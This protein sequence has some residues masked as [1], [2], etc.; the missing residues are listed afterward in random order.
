[1]LQYEN[2][3][4]ARKFIKIHKRP[5][6]AQDLRLKCDISKRATYRIINKLESIGF[7]KKISE[8]RY[9]RIYVHVAQPE[10]EYISGK[11]LKRNQ[12]GFDYEKMFEIIGAVKEHSFKNINQLAKHLSFSKRTAYRFIKSMLNAKVLEVEYMHI[13][14]TRPNRIEVVGK[15]E[16][17]QARSNTRNK[18][19]QI[20][21]ANVEKTLIDAN[22]V[23]YPA[24]IV[25]PQMVS[26]DTVVMKSLTR[27]IKLSQRIHEDKKALSKAMN[28]FLKRKDSPTTENTELISFDGKFKIEIQAD[29]QLSSNKQSFTFYSRESLD[30]PFSQVQLDF[31]LI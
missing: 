10:G 23:T 18:T 3:Q 5:F 26:Q 14:A 1:M 12:F 19:P 24:S 4:L 29:K 27:A 9:R 28:K 6:T 16:A 25:E 30:K 31:S 15:L 13:R 7:I 11:E 8:G 20:A 22:G 21:S 17:K 2:E